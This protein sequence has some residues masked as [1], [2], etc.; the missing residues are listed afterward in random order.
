[1]ISA[2]Q[3]RRLERL[4]RLFDARDAKL[5]SERDHIRAVLARHRVAIPALDDLGELDDRDAEAHE[6]RYGRP[7]SEEW[8]LNRRLL[9]NLSAALYYAAIDC[10][11]V[12]RSC[13]WPD[14]DTTVEAQRALIGADFQA[15]EKAWPREH[16]TARR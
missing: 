6:R 2:S 9:W 1:M 14:P 16:L 11:E 12:R 15:L 3:R 4:E 8:C 7:P 13:G 10:A 5:E